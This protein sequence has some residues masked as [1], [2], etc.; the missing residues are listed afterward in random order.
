MV[1][2]SRNFE[3]RAISRKDG[4][5]CATSWLCISICFAVQYIIHYIQYSLADIIYAVYTGYMH[6]CV[7]SVQYMQYTH[8][9]CI[10]AMQILYMGQYTIYSR[11]Y[12]QYIILLR[13]YMVYGIYIEYILYS[14]VQC[15]YTVYYIEQCIV[16]CIVQYRICGHAPRLAATSYVC[17]V[18]V[19]SATMLGHRYNHQP[20][21]E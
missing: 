7:Y 6:A 21:I 13:Y 2:L 11:V 12:I 14:I 3:V 16:Y 4:I 18:Q 5:N 9:C 10:H 20:H 19:V 17:G 1:F 8:I 15:I